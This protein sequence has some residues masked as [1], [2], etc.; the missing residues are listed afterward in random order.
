MILIHYLWTISR[1]VN[2]HSEHKPFVHSD[3]TTHKLSSK[4]R[5]NAAYYLKHL[6]NISLSNRSTCRS[7]T[8]IVLD[9]SVWAQSACHTVPYTAADPLIHSILLRIN[10]PVKPVIK[11]QPAPLLA[12]SL[13]AKRRHGRVP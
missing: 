10:Y 1:K 2:I 6:L 8:D 4:H 3:A 11:R 7:P 13:V 9:D 12:K 5:R